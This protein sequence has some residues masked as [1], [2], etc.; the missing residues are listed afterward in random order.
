MVEPGFRGAEWDAG[1][2][3]NFRQGHT[4]DKTHQ[5]DLAVIATQFRDD[6]Q[7]V[8]MSGWS[9]AG[10]FELADKHGSRLATDE[11]ALT[12][13]RGERVVADCG[14]KEGAQLAAQLE[15]GEF[16]E[17]ITENFLQHVLGKMLAPADPA[18]H[19]EDPIPMPVVKD[20]EG[21]G[22]ARVDP[23]DKLGIIG[24]IFLG[25]FRQWD[26]WAVCG[27]HLAGN[28]VSIKWT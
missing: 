7:D 28:T 22:I 3:G 13:Q 25:L 12:A 20:V 16:P 5:E 24:H 15:A 18:G 14:I 27:M 8:V 26:K 2:S 19:A 10:G 6:V 11:A 4:I 21:V 9:V 23:F 17:E 1:K